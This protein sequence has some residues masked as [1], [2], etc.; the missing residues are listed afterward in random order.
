MAPWILGSGAAHLLLAAL[1]IFWPDLRPRGPEALPPP[2]FDIVFEGGQPE[3]PT[4]DAAPGL[5]VPPAPPSLEA[6]PGAAPPTPPLAEAPPEPPPPPPVP[7]TAQAPA[8]PPAPLPPAPLPP[9]QA[10][11]PPP[12]PSPVAPRPPPPPAPALAA[13]P[14]PEP[15]PPLPLPA[16]APPALAEAPRVAAPPA[17]PR[18][19]APPAV[20]A[21]PPEPE[22]ERAEVPAEAPPDL[23]APPT[24]L[25]LPERFA[26]PLPPP[27]TPTPPPRPQPRPQQQARPDLPG[28]WAPEGVQIGPPAPPSGR[29]QGRGLD[30]RVD[31]RLAEGRAVSDPNLRVT[32]AQ[33][34]AD[35]RAAFR[36]WLDQNLRYPERAIQLGEDGAVRVQ[37]VASPDGTVR[38]VRLMMP[39]TSPSLNFGTTFPFQGA[40]LPPF[41]PPADP[42]GVVIDLTVNYILIRR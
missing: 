27:P 2:A 29:P 10:A 18:P 37:V 1:L 12:P 23:L 3:R 17:P 16:P 9:A 39:S 32:G 4:E 41:P 7:P 30:T 15:P 33:V 6:P 13:A 11:A 35:W 42:N 20:E 28:I 38:S 5:E 25:R 26:L 8:P 31:P 36:R 22:P 19:E 24:P 40:R 14:R 34:G 21:F